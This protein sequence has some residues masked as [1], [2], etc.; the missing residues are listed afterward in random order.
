MIHPKFCPTRASAPWQIKSVRRRRKAWLR[1][2]GKHGADMLIGIAF[3]QHQLPTPFRRVGNSPWPDTRTCGP[4]K[5]TASRAAAR[6]GKWL[7]RTGT[8]LYRTE[9][10]HILQPL[11]MPPRERNLSGR[12]SLFALP[13]KRGRAAAVAD[14]TFRKV[15]EYSAESTRVLAA[16]YA[17]A[18]RRALPPLPHAS[19]VP[20]GRLTP[21]IR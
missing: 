9:D 15:L 20:T 6:R 12:L 2:A 13:Q 10:V 21:P 3:L 16:E 8:G 5:R 14:C 18:L 7:T 11:V 4:M 17:D 1:H 19:P